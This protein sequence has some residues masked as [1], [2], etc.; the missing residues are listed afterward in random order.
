MLFQSYHQARHCLTNRP[1]QAAVTSNVK[2]SRPPP[3]RCLVVEVWIAIAGQSRGCKFNISNLKCN[4]ISIG[5]GNV[6]F[7][8]GGSTS[9][10]CRQDRVQRQRSFAAIWL[11]FVGKDNA[12]ANCS[13]CLHDVHTAGKRHVAVSRESAKWKQ[14]RVEMFNAT[15]DLLWLTFA[16]VE[17]SET[18]VGRHLRGARWTNKPRVVSIYS[19]RSCYKICVVMGVGLGWDLYTLLTLFFFWSLL[20]FLKHKKQLFFFLNLFWLQFMR[21]RKEKKRA[22]CCCC[23][24]L[25]LKKEN[26]FKVWQRTL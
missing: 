13:H 19:T 15:A 22:C 2:R 6:G 5:S 11:H 7:S 18:V 9:P 24:W 12:A 1:S 14:H 17:S 25:P 21:K 10:L 8:G 20:F 16:R 23:S 3:L 4:S 26:M